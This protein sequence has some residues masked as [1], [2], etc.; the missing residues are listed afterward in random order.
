[1]GKRFALARGD[2][3]AAHIV[4]NEVCVGAHSGGHHR[5]GT[6]HRL[7]NG[8]RHAFTPRG[9]DE[10]VEAPQQEAEVP[11]TVDPQHCYICKQKFTTV[12]HFYDQMCPPCA[13]TIPLAIGRPRP[14]PSRRSRVVACQNRSK[15]CGTLSGAMPAPESATDGDPTPYVRFDGVSSVAY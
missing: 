5:Q 14:A 8:V 15:T 3:V 1:M 9:Q 11:P 4:M 6:R 10:A 13:S 12:H 7:E 2:Q